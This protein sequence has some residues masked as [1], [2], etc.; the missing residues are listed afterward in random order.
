MIFISYRRED[1]KEVVTHLAQRLKDR[2][3]SDKIFVDFNDIA[4]GADWPETLR[5]QLNACKV[6]LGVVGSGWGD[7]RFPANTGKRSNRL[8]LD[9]R[10]DWVR[11]E[12]C[13][14]VQRWKA[15]SAALIVV[16]VD[17]ATLPETG[18][19]CEL[20]EL[21]NVQQASL[22]NQK[23]FERDFE[24]LCQALEQAAPELRTPFKKKA[25]L[26]L[27]RGKPS[28][29]NDTAKQLDAYRQT[30]IVKTAKLRL[31][32]IAPNGAPVVAPIAQLRI[33]LPLLLIHEHA[34]EEREAPPRWP[35]Q[36]AEN[37]NDALRRSHTDAVMVDRAARAED[38]KR[39]CALPSRLAP[40]KRMV[41]LG[42]PGCGKSTLLQW[43]AH[44][45]ASNLGDDS[46][47]AHDWLPV[48]IACRDLLPRTPGSA[49]P[50]NLGELLLAHCHER[51]F[52]SAA[53]AALRKGIEKRFQAGHAILLIDG[54]D[55]I[56]QSDRRRAFCGMIAAIAE[57]F[58]ALP[59]IVTSRVVGF[60]A[61][62]DVLATQ[63]DHL[64]VGPLDHGAK[65]HF[66]T[67]W[68]GLIG[69]TPPVVETL[70]WQVC[71]ARTTAKL[72]DNV[73]LLALVAQLQAIDRA[74]PKRRVDVYRRAVELMIERRRGV[75]GDALSLNEVVP[76]L[77]DLA[78]HMRRRGVQRLSDVDVI[79]RFTLLRQAEAGEH[80]LTAHTPERL[81]HACIE[82]AGLLNI[83]GSVTDD[84]GY[85]RRQVQF[86]HQSFQEYFA[87]QAIKHG[88]S[89]VGT[90]ALKLREKLSELM[91]EDRKVKIFDTYSISEPVLAGQW[92]E[93]VRLLIA[94]LP[95]GDADD[96]L[97][98]LLPGPDANAD[99]ARARAVFALQCL[100]E[101]PAVSETTADAVF[102]ALIDAIREDDGF[103]SNRNTWMDEALA[104]MSQSRFSN[105]LQVRL[106]SSFIEMRN[107]RRRDAGR[108]F[109]VLNR[110]NN[111]PL[112]EE[113]ARIFINR[114][115]TGIS[116]SSTGDRIQSALE[117]M[118]ICYK[119]EG[120]VGFLTLEERTA[121]FD[122]LSSA[123]E[124]DEATASAALWALGWMC[125]YKYND[126]SPDEQDRIALPREVADRVV[127]AL[128]RT[129]LDDVS[130]SFGAKL[131]TRE[132]GLLPL[133][134][135][136]DWIYDLAVVADGGSPRKRLPLV[137]PVGMKRRLTWLRD[138]LSSIRNARSRS[139]IATAL[140]SVGEFDPDLVTELRDTAIDSKLIFE[141][142]REA[143]LYL[144]MLG[145]PQAKAV[146][147]EFADTA[148]NGNDDLTY[149]NGLF[150]LLYV[151]D[152][153]ILAGQISKALPH[154][155]L[156]AYCFGL[157]G[158]R[159]PRGPERLKSLAKDKNSR[160]REAAQKAL[161]KLDDPAWADP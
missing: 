12:L 34:P 41:V 13:T 97:L 143:A 16:T 122:A 83:A 111:Q 128:Q 36:A 153:E 44:H 53:A 49:L 46:L 78:Y 118:E 149:S 141:E 131:L 10:D 104:A 135:Q 61:V 9:D 142:R 161:K 30:T 87:G 89:E 100:A 95:V 157:A 57:R 15:K 73:L 62:R 112:T 39:D 102:D 151:D 132:H 2:Y 77:E 125:S 136:Q 99:E 84:R 107:D 75:D 35:T 137:K 117:F 1:T 144:S 31:P 74:L 65:Q 28:R 37:L 93:T 23:D 20:D 154:S 58:A 8:R 119:S 121:L 27:P 110:Q 150:G 114:L 115:Q 68:G 140:F 91:V 60:D 7:A 18:W 123:L 3:G 26:P 24:A 70:V 11:Q 32:L 155:D 63:F 158:S 55:E 21:G 113:N 5:Q 109:L 88:R 81:L 103:N 76:H 130:I 6:V 47:P 56:P 106:L 59:I 94:D 43:V 22:R 64:L 145:T 38:I 147:I 120:K 159:D 127:L 92:Q 156:N 148:P 50:E 86:F 52:A 51:Q 124:S 45:Y 160:I 67:R 152:I 108:C 19:E 79:A 25:G 101:E 69:W 82:S 116:S 40:G 42:D 17:G 105:H 98:M 14:A 129:D 29:T 80:A 134:V 139:M 33:D 133:Y 66:V 54:L 4:P 71:H 90:A 96:A 48:L 72:T 85:D 138:K 126:T 146:L